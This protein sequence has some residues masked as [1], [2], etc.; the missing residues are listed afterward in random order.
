M[1]TFLCKEPDA[2]SQPT[3]GKRCLLVPSSL[4]SLAAAKLTG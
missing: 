4:R 2:V 3:A 1:S